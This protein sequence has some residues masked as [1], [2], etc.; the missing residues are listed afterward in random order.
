[1]D[2]IGALAQWTSEKFSFVTVGDQK[3]DAP[4]IRE[5][6][7]LQEALEY[8]GVSEKLS[9][10]KFPD[11]TKTSNVQ[12][13]KENGR[14]LFSASYDLYGEAF[15]ISIRKIISRPYGEIEINAPNVEIYKVN[16]IDHYLMTDV[17]QSKV[18]WRNG[19]WECFIAGNLSRHDV[20][21]MIDSIY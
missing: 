20:V 12:V 3:D 17:K 16:G 8:G 13:S 9:P 6:T 5:F 21:T 1:M 19:E 18:M 11:G 10:T 2:I 4:E 14:V 7:S 15:Y